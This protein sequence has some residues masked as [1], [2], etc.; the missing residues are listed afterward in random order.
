MPAGGAERSAER[1]LAGAGF[2]FDAG[3]S[4]ANAG[5]QFVLSGGAFHDDRDLRVDVAGT[6]ARVEA[7]IRGSGNVKDDSAGR[8]AHFPV[9]TGGWV[10][11]HLHI[12]ATGVH[13]KVSNDAAHG[14]TAAAAR[15]FHCLS[16]LNDLNIARA[17]LGA[18]F[19]ENIGERDVAGAGR[20]LHLPFNVRELDIA[21][22]RRYLHVVGNIRGRDFAGAGHEGCGT[23]DAADVDIS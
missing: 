18:D 16:G 12:A 17:R 22:A 10:S 1:D 8:C 6:G 7:E 9:R 3:F 23:F 19:T 11:V 14:D 20:G 4:V 5:A 21:T 2:D 13:T 15:R